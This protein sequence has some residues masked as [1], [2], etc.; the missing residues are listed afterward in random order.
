MAGCLYLVSTPI[1]HPDDISL[2][3]LRILRHVSVIAAE[4]PRVTQRLLAQ[5]DIDT[6]LTS[7]Q[8]VNKE[9]KAPVLVTWMREGKDVALV[10]DAGTPVITDPGHFLV[11]QALRHHIDVIPIPGPFTPA[12]ALPASGLPSDGFLFHGYLPSGQ[13]RRRSL[14]NRLK[15]EERTLIFFE[16]PRRLR[17][18][19]DAMAQVLGNRRMVLARDLTR[20][21]EEYIRG[22]V[23]QIMKIRPQRLLKGDVTLL[24]EGFREPRGKS[25]PRKRPATR[26]RA[27]GS[28]RGKT[29]RGVPG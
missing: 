17:A 9:D 23:L 28:R 8:N 13:H 20:P 7:Y 11:T 21:S 15:A 3:A 25:R 19:L 22:R 26:S 14:L 2:R 6:P 29:A 24:V 18:S 5:H 1:G 16:T 10:S 4:D 12:V 27:S